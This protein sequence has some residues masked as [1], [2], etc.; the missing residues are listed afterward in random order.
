MK[1]GGGVVGE[2]AHAGDVYALFVGRHAYQLAV[3]AH[4]LAYDHVEQF[5][6]GHL[7]V[8]YG[9]VSGDDAQSPS[10]HGDES[11][12]GVRVGVRLLYDLLHL[13]GR[14]LVDVHG[15]HLGGFHHVAQFLAPSVHEHGGGDAG[16]HH[17]GLMGELAADVPVLAIVFS[18]CLGH[19]VEGDD[20]L[21][22]IKTGELSAFAGGDSIE[23]RWQYHFLSLLLFCCCH[24]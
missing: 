10:A 20:P 5:Q 16:H 4:R 6:H 21:Q 1:V 22:F 13:L 24:F 8:I 9:Q 12:H 17:L 7:V 18:T 19:G 15:E 3:I 14:N 11:H 2:S 23:E